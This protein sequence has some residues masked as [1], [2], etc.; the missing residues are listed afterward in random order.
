[1]QGI[2]AGLKFRSPPIDLRDDNLKELWKI[3]VVGKYDRNP[4]DTSDINGG[5]RRN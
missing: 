3:D 5:V 4:L 1:M 2:P